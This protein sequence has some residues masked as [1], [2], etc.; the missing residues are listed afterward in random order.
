MT[1]SPQH[2]TISV[3]SSEFVFAGFLGGTVIWIQMR[4]TTA[5]TEWS[6]LW[7]KSEIVLF[8]SR[9]LPIRIPQ[10][11]IQTLAWILAFGLACFESTKTKGICYS[12]SLSLYSSDMSCAPTDLWKLS[13]FHEDL[14]VSSSAISRYF[15]QIFKPGWASGTNFP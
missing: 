6:L 3:K 8:I 9:E 13:P 14:H 1:R 12:S 11:L 7:V 4:W 5:Q 10:S 15:V 2:F